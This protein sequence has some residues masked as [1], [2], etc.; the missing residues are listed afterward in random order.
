MSQTWR[1]FTV[2]LTP[3]QWARINFECG[4]RPRTVTGKRVKPATIIREALDAH[5][6]TLD[7]ADLRPDATEG[8]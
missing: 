3:E 8:E 7:V 4:A 1:R 6:A 5:F 2:L